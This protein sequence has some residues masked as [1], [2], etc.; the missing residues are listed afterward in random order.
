MRKGGETLSSDGVIEEYLDANGTVW[1][2]AEGRNVIAIID[3]FMGR[4]GPGLGRIR[5]EKKLK[6]TDRAP[7]L[8][9]AEASLDRKPMATLRGNAPMDVE[10][11]IKSTDLEEKVIKIQ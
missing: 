3:A 2:R 11:A 9:S 5:L 6:V 4:L 7:Q 8:A 1:R 10:Q